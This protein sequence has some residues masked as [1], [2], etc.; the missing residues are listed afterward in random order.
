MKLGVP[1]SISL[2]DYTAGT[3]VSF[4]LTGPLEIRLYWTSNKPF[5]KM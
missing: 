2:K 3:F 1:R 5:R 4:L